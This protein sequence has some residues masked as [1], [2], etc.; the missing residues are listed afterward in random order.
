VR[1]QRIA[2]YVV[3]TDGDRLLLS[4]LSDRTMRPGWWTLPGGGIE[5][6][7]HPETA[8]LRELHE[9]AGLEGRIIGLLAVDSFTGPIEFDDG[10]RI[11]HRI[12]IIYRADI[13]G[14]EL[15]PEVE[16]SSDDAR[17]F[18]PSEL[19]GIRLTEPAR[20]GMSLAWPTA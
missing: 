18:T 9:E 16:G 4:R 15:R 6:G 19:D 1:D 13:T 12:R 11:L 17:W 3:A 5:F 2:A 20:L 14:G 10:P 8:A 7:E